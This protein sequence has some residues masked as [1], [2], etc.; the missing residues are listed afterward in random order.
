MGDL[1]GDP[2]CWAH[3]AG[4]LATGFEAIEVS[5]ES[6]VVW[7]LPHG[8]GLDANIVRLVAHDSIGEHVN[9]D[10]DVLLV[11]W[12][13]SGEVV[14]DERRVPLEPGVITC[15]ERGRRRSVHAGGDGLMYLSTHPRL[16]PMSVR[17]AD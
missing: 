11:V 8:G 7:S 16:D 1:G 4:D 9:D 13:G 6:G 17:R 12:S 3:P 10:L 2:A 15:V 14:V 5:D